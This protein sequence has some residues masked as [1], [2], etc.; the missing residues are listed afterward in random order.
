MQQCSNTV[1]IMSEPE[2]NLIVLSTAKGIAALDFY[3]A[4]GFR[5]EMTSSAEGLDYYA[6]YLGETVIEI[7]PGSAGTASQ[8]CQG[9]SV[10]LGLKVD[11][12]DEVLA[13][14]QKLSKITLPAAHESRW[15]RRVVL[16]DP[17]GRKI[18]LIERK[19]K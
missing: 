2:L 14:A 13:K 3:R 6:C 17:D 5:F 10:M 18:Q 11:N 9:S 7:H 15:G 4:L 16:T 1:I 19:I 8:P 12:I